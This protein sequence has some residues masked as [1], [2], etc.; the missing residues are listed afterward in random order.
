MSPLYT[1]FAVTLSPFM[2]L[3]P[4]TLAVPVINPIELCLTSMAG[5]K[6]YLPDIT[7]RIMVATPSTKDVAE[8]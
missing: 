6:H 2:L 5:N 1:L 7:G 8:R 4:S 3:F